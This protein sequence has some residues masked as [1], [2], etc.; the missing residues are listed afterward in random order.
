MAE[1]EAQRSR[2]ACTIRHVRHVAA[3][4]GPHGLHG[5]RSRTCPTGAEVAATAAYAGAMPFI[6]RCLGCLYQGKAIG[7][8]GNPGSPIV[9]VGEAPG[10]TEVDEGEPFVG[11]AGG[12]LRDALA[13]A[14]IDEASAFIT[15][16][17]ACR[18]LNPAKP[19]RTPT[20]AAIDACH[21][22]LAHDL[23]LN[24]GA[25]L[26]ALGATAVQ[27]LTGQ[28]EFPVRNEHGRV[29]A[30]K[31]GRVVA[32]V[33]P[34]SGLHRPADRATLFAMLVDDLKDARRLAGLGEDAVEMRG[35]DGRTSVRG[36]PEPEEGADQPSPRLFTTPPLIRDILG[37]LNREVVDGLRGAKQIRHP[38]ESGRARENI[39][40]DALRRFVPD[41]FGVSTGFVI[42]AVG[43]I[44]RQQD[45]VVYR[46]GYHPIFTVGGVDH[47]MVE[48]VVAVIQNRAS[49]TSRDGLVDALDTVA[50]V[51]AL[52]RT[53]RGTNYVIQGSTR[54][55]NVRA[56]YYQHQVWAGIVTEASLSAD[57]LGPTMVAYLASKD[58]RLWP[59]V[60]ADVNGRAGLYLV[61]GQWTDVPTPGADW[62]LT[63]PE[64]N[65]AESVP[66]FV[67][68]I[69]HLANYLRVAPL[70]DYKPASYL[71]RY[72]GRVRRW[73]IAG[74]MIKEP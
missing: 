64:E 45:I 32:T 5:A 6:N 27:A 50:S 40:A 3:Y 18:P 23:E 15:N 57:A 8:H 31:W 65:V 19:I 49:I 24:P 35:G 58:P 37:R 44:S 16:S 25:V 51:K 17:V 48:S 28:R 20:P 1:V 53:N 13:A 68:L 2:S 62:A 73:A 60:Y 14:Q 74:A 21:G 9:L 42:D 29:L 67:E 43:G 30:S 66:P 47:F 61:N 46:R 26:V 34:A 36:A 4:D 39:V 71:P 55:E 7:P 41:L 10:S 70:V 22:R 69:D 33:H 12:V 56:D 11:D 63:S 52:D 72:E 38:G 59:N 54:G